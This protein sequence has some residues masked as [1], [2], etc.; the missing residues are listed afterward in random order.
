MTATPNS[1]A[2]PVR[3]ATALDLLE[4]IT[5]MIRRMATVALYVD[6]QD[7]AVDFWTK[8]AGFEVRTRRSLGEGLGSWVE[9]APSG[10]DSCLVLYPR[11]LSPDWAERKPSIVFDCEDVAA[12]VAR[13]KARGVM[14]SQELTVMKWGPFATFLDTEGNEHGLRERQS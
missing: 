10:A 9:V 13:M 8:Q 2:L 14:F 12:T 3:S 1:S 5:R 11:A 4:G 7:A 6:D